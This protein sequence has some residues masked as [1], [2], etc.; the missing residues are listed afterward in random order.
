MSKRGK[1][2]GGAVFVAEVVDPGLR[3]DCSQR[4]I[5]VSENGAVSDR[6]YKNARPARHWL[7]ALALL[8]VC[9]SPVAGL[10]QPANCEAQPPAPNELAHASSVE[11]Y[12][13]VLKL[14][15]NG[16]VRRIATR[17]L[18]LSG[19]SALL[20]VDPESLHTD[21]QAASCWTCR[22][23]G[24]DEVADTRFMHAIAQSA[25]APGLT[26][27]GFL[28]N[29]GL[30]H[31]AGA[32]VYLTGD[33]CPSSKPFDRDF[34]ERVAQSGPHTPVAL[35]ISGLWLIRHFQDYRWILDKQA[36]GAIDVLW[37]NHSYHHQFKRG[38]SFDHN[39]LLTPGVDPDAEI[40]DTERLL[41]ANGQ[42]P[43]VFFRFPGLISSAPLMQ[44][45]RSHHLVSLGADAWLALR[46]KPTQG[47]IV[48]VHPNGNEP[49]GLKI[50]A[51]DVEDGTM[52]LPLK[53]LVDA[54]P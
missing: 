37:T 22:D 38:V 40:L 1:T 28:E 49:A 14:C 8:A 24:E 41:I 13:S 46:Q 25:D 35:S 31:G 23:I 42:T 32:G 39:F 43:S 26:K 54:P 53:A 18:R 27:R 52:P 29:A 44:A 21:L 50:Y 17:T 36:A 15:S 34:L 6:G 3:A 30:T 10:A 19:K 4:K 16:G 11:D 48:L 7:A 33:L 45:A 2:T 51:H 5:P 9:L 47:S 20:L 12:R